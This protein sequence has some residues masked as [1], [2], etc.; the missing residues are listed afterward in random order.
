[1]NFCI[2]LAVLMTSVV[3]QREFDFSEESF[4]SQ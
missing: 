1:M 4:T 2:I 3:G